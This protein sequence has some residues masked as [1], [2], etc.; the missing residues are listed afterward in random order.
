LIEEI[1]MRP[2]PASILTGKCAREFVKKVGEPP[3]QKN[4]EV[5]KE[6]EKTSRAIRQIQ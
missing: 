4:V 2:E 3:T 5:F 1:K 6:A